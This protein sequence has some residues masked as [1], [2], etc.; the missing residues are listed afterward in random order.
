MLWSGFIR[1]SHEPAP[2]CSGFRAIH[3]LLPP[4]RALC[5]P[6]LAVF[7]VCHL[8]GCLDQCIGVLS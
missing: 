2:F 8:C 3:A 6:D 5:V 1:F 4:S 7:G